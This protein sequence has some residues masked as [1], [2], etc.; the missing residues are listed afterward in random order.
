MQQEET[1]QTEALQETQSPAG[2]VEETEETQE[3]PEV[4]AEESYAF[5]IDGHKFKTQEEAFNFAKQQL[6]QKDADLATLDAYNRG[7]MD[8]TKQPSVGQNVTPP[9]E[10]DNFEERFYSDPKAALAEVQRRAK[11]EAIN[12][13]RQMTQAEKADQEAWNEFTSHYPE[14]ADFREDVDSIAV[15]HKAQIQALVQA[16]KRKQAIDLVATKVKA[17]FDAYVQRSKPRKELQ[18]TDATLPPVST[19]QNVTPKKAST[20]PVDFLS[21]IRTLK[22]SRMKS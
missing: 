16:G 18:R 7:L 12:E 11:E 1:Q 19:G 10:E 20:Q 22:K 21:Q 2:T 6:T 14:L 9:P 13:M 3:S 5:E 17:K 4:P 8:A 15:K